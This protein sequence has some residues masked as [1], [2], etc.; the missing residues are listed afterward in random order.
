MG[1][2]SHGTSIDSYATLRNENDTKQLILNE[3]LDVVLESTYFLIR[4]NGDMLNATKSNFLNLFK[5]NKQNI[6]EYLKL[7]KLNFNKESDLKKLLNF[8]TNPISA[9]TASY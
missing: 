8:C 2:P 5:K 3:D 9:S 7:N 6:E 4:N 1:I